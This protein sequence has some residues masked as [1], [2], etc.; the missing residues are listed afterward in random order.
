MSAP[1]HPRTAAPHR[2]LLAV[3]L[4]AFACNH[5]SVGAVTV[6]EESEGALRI[7]SRHYTAVVEPARG[8]RITSLVVDGAETTRLTDDGA[9]GL[10]EEVHT[11]RQ[12]YRVL[13]RNVSDD[14]LTLELAARTGDL[15]VV[16]RFE[17][18]DPRPYITVRWRFE[19]RSP[20][21]LSGPDAPA[22]RNLALPADGRATGRELY[23][24]DRGRGAE[25]LN[26][27]P[28]LA[29]LHGSTAGPSL[30]WTAVAE[31]AVRRAL[32]FRPGSAGSRPLPPTR[33]DGGG[34]LVGWSYPA[35]PPGKA[36]GAQMLIAPLP[37]FTA[38]TGLNAHVAVDSV[39]D[40]ETRP[41]RVRFSLLAFHTLREVSVV[42]RAYGPEGREL[43]P[44]EP[45]LFDRLRG[46]SAK[47]GII[48]CTQ[49]SSRPAWLVHEVYA[50][51]E[52]VGTAV[53]ALDKPVGP[54]P[55]TDSRQGGSEAV[56]LDSYDVA[57]PWGKLVAEAKSRGRSF[58]VWRFLGA[59]HSTELKELSLT[60]LAGEKRTLFLGVYGLRNL[61]PFEV[62]LDAGDG[63]GDAS[64][65]PPAA[66][67][68]WRVIE[69]AGGGAWLE[70][71]SPARLR[72]EQ[73]LWMAV[74]LDA[75]RLSPGR[76]AGRLT[77]G[78]GSDAKAVPLRLRVLVRP[79][80]AGGPFGLSYLGSRNADS[81]GVPAAAGDF[82]IDAWFLSA[83]ETAPGRASAGVELA[84]AGL[85]RLGLKRADGV[86]PPSRPA[87]ALALPLPV[88]WWLLRSDAVSPAAWQATVKAGYTP[89]VQCRRIG[90]ADEAPAARPPDDPSAAW[91]VE[92]GV[93]PGRV[94]SL[95]RSRRLNGSDEVWLYMD[96]QRMDW[97]RAALRIP[98]AF[99]AA[100]AQGLAGAAVR[101][102]PPGRDVE[103]QQAVW[104]IV[105]NARNDVALWRGARR[106]AGAIVRSVPERGAERRRRMLLLQSLN[107]LVGS[108]SDFALQLASEPGPGLRH[109]VLPAPGAERLSR[110]QFTRARGEL[111]ALTERLSALPP[112]EPDGPL[113]WWD[114]PLTSD[115][116]TQWTILITGGEA[117]RDA[118]LQFQRLVER[119]R[120]LTIPVSR[121][122][123][124]IEDDEAA[125]VW[126][127]AGPRGNDGLP[128]RLAEGMRGDPS[129]PLALA[130]LEGRRAVVVR[131]EVDPGALA[132][133]LR[134][135]R[136]VYPKARNVR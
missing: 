33:A 35:V 86:L 23:C 102:R 91:L 51:G 107:G 122:A 17:F 132:A 82:G 5:G 85:E 134:T 66:L 2:L 112:P 43:K 101:C 28:F 133:A 47:T 93:P 37:D 135:E 111:L 104:H 81:A 118:A 15:R 89:A 79:P 45:L 128:P 54:A 84:Y 67:Y 19:N 27:E 61:R 58:A 39:P 31:P 106:A 41:S 123:E 110:R 29:R 72:P 97:R 127:F 26:R 30:R 65:V 36:L 136:Q 55:R 78:T 75:E 32:G 126:V 114:V 38:V 124:R 52:L 64:A 56:P 83:D 105:R 116:R 100:A 108:S 24:I 3:V 22:V 76:Y 68:L 20:F 40:T 95:L 53:D 96:L 16:K 9:G 120:G 57:S 18:S 117:S 1:L 62:N 115:G 80:W 131:P 92:G 8:G 13:H 21:P 98:S 121:D 99:W 7:R 6:S 63:Q 25:V 34:L 69:G 50:R 59:P 109:G 12:R 14:E 48:H 129:G 74:T 70:P 90:A 125:L 88:P 4:T 103:R 94:P 73:T 46:L 60:L 130:R 71:F 113:Y 10:T 49:R 77:F 44:C 119:K 11:R 42:T 87:P